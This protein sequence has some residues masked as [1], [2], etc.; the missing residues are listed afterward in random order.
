[1]LNLVDYRATVTTRISPTR[2]DSG[3]LIG[4]LQDI[5]YLWYELGSESRGYRLFLKQIV[6]CGV[7]WT[8]RGLEAQRPEDEQNIT[9]ARG[10]AGWARSLLGKR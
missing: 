2:F 9:S 10:D 8:H 3:A 5:L 1:M 4:D 6:C 7:E